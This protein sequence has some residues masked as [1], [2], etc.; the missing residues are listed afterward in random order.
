MLTN[1]NR[2][3][4]ERCQRLFSSEGVIYTPMKLVD[5]YFFQIGYLLDTVEGNS[6]E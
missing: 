2:E 5:M 4:F 6:E 3:E 1:Q